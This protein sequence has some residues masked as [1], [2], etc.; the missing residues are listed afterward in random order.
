[1]TEVDMG[2]LRSSVSCVDGW[3][4]VPHHRPVRRHINDINVESHKQ[5]SKHALWTLY[6]CSP[7]LV[8]LGMIEN[9][10][11]HGHEPTGLCQTHL[12]KVSWVILVKEYSVMMLSSS[13]SATSRMLSVLA[14][15]TVSRTD[16]PPLFPCLLKICAEQRASRQRPAVSYS[17][18]E[19]YGSRTADKS[20]TKVQAKPGTRLVRLVQGQTACLCY[21]EVLCVGTGRWQTCEGSSTYV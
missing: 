16:V 20:K 6:M 7:C 10:S 15:T 13:I 19:I 18:D 5:L 11:R 21:R 1:M 14:D 3:L 9:D 8:I 4:L 12:A 2:K 17:L